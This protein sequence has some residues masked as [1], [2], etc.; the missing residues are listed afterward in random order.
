MVMIILLFKL[1][2]ILN[3]KL[4]FQSTLIYGFTNVSPRNEIQTS[5][6]TSCAVHKQSI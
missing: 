6:G 2:S 1:S 4:T 3:I 5:T